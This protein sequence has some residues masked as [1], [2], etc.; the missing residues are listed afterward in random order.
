[1]P[2]NPKNYTHFQMIA[3]E[4]PT[5]HPA[6]AGGNAP[7]IGDVPVEDPG[8]ADAY[9]RLLRLAWV[10]EQAYQQVFAAGDN[11]N[12]LKV[13]MVPEFYFRPDDGPSNSYDMVT[14]G[15]IVKALSSMFANDKFEHWLFVVGSIFYYVDAV[16]RIHWNDAYIVKGGYT[17]IDLPTKLVTKRKISSID[18]ANPISSPANHFKLSDYLGTW[19]T[20]QKNLGYID[21]LLYG[22]EIC[23]DHGLTYEGGKKGFLR[24]TAKEYSVYHGTP[25]PVKLHFLTACGMPLEPCAVAAKVGGYV[26]RVDGHYCCQPGIWNVPFS[27]CAK[28][29]AQD[30]EG[31]V[32]LDANLAE[33]WHFDI[34]L[35]QRAPVV[36]NP[37]EVAAVTQRVVAYQVAEL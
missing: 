29:T 8:N 35:L 3:Y 23:L 4:T 31:G 19:A 18:G 14:G 37:V 36:A 2:Y 12:T 34:P 7:A 24:D 5:L 27:Q 30:L 32:T 33:A 28:V 13:F 6:P 20:R 9:T 25:Y 22:I 10:V 1:M 11:A 21:N 15:A 26:L 16:T 17:G